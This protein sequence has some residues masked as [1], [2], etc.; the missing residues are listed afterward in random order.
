MAIEFGTQI[1][2][3]QGDDPGEAVMLDS[4]GQVPG[5]NGTGMKWTRIPFGTALTIG[6]IYKI[7]GIYGSAEFVVPNSVQFYLYFPISVDTSSSRYNGRRVQI[8]RDGSGIIWAEGVN[9][10]WSE[11][12]GTSSNTVLFILEE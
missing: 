2:A 10:D 12:T 3:V 7:I 6:R 1:K 9:R 4:N 5:E 8:K 11:T